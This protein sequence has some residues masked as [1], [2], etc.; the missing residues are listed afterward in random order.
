[1]RGLSELSTG[2]VVVLLCI[3]IAISLPYAMRELRRDWTKLRG[4]FGIA[5]CLICAGSAGRLGLAWFSLHI[6]TMPQTAY[7]KMVE[8]FG[9]FLTML[10][11]G[12]ILIAIRAMTVESQGEKIWV[13][14]VCAAAVLSIAVWVL[15]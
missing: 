13:R 15:F 12:G 9:V 7:W 3:G 14:S 11:S 8:P 6:S 5:F 1:M 2:F 4:Q 10:I